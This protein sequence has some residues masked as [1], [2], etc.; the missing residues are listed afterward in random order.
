MQWSDVL[1]EPTLQ[2]LPFKIELSTW[3][4]ME[5]SPTNTRQGRIT[6]RVVQYLDERLPAG[7]ILMNTATRTAAG[8]RIADVSR[9]LEAAMQSIGYPS[10]HPPSWAKH[11]LC[12]HSVRRNPTAAFAC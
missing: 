9:R 12:S 1:A 8:A 11:R 5:M 4:V 6:G 7:E 10:P 3:G 2:D